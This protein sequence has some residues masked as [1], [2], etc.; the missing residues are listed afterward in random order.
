MYMIEFGYTNENERKRIEYLFGKDTDT[1]RRVKT[2]AYLVDD[3]VF[4][5]MQKEIEEKFTEDV[6]TIYKVE[7]VPFVR[8]N[9]NFDLIRESAKSSDQ[10]SSFLNYLVSRK[11]GVFDS[12]DPMGSPIYKVYTRKGLVTLKYS[13][14][15]KDKCKIRVIFDGPQD[16]AESLRDEFIKELDVFLD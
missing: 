2:Y 12:N 13:V 6:V 7:K 9:A 15:G 10:V 3:N 16:A 4:E 8:N 14:T 5:K 11:R 1:N